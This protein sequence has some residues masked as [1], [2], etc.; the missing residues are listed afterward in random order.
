MMRWPGPAHQTL[1]F[2]AAAPRV[3]RG[4]GRYSARL[5]RG[6]RCYQTLPFGTVALCFRGET[7]RF[8]QPPGSVPEPALPHPGLR[9]LQINTDPGPGTAAALGFG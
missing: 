7:E 3:H 8:E 4:D 1:C 2:I 5:L 9:R 6:C